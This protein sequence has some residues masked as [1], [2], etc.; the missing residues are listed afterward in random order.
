MYIYLFITI[1]ICNQS[2]RFLGGVVVKGII[3]KSILALREID[4]K[5]NESV[6]CKVFLWGEG[7]R[8]G[9]RLY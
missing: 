9:G 7:E 1:T 6:F 4:E 5:S 2:G 8:E 3:V